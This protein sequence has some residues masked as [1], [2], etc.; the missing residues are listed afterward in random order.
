MNAQS[1]IVFGALLVTLSCRCLPQALQQ[2]QPSSRN[3]LQSSYRVKYH[4]EFDN[5][6]GNGSGIHW[7][8]D[9]VKAVDAFGR[10]YEESVS[11]GDISKKS[12]YIIDPV[13][14]NSFQWIDGVDRVTVLKLHSLE[15]T[16]A[17]IP[18]TGSRPKII[19]RTSAQSSQDQEKHTYEDLGSRTL[20]G[21]PATGKRTTTIIPA[22]LWGN[23]VE[24]R[25]VSEHWTAPST[26]I[27][28]YSRVE[29][30]DW[31]RRVE[32][33]TEFISEEPP[34]SQFRPPSGYKLVR[35]DGSPLKESELKECSSRR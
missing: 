35:A 29:G 33:A 17:H 14:D 21:I 25:T 32:T 4:V 3:A 28:L 30:P 1:R 8:A 6:A 22:G 13:C 7:E 34:L 23:D 19:T 12:Y 2:N 20:I 31:G 27:S 15:S 5:T 26:G 18:E 9:L 11:P 24:M 16:P 10:R